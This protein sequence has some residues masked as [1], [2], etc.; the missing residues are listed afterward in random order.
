[1]EKINPGTRPQVVWGRGARIES[2]PAVPRAPP[3][4]VPPIRAR[5]RERGHH[6]HRAQRPGRVTPR[7]QSAARPRL[8]PPAAAAAG[9]SP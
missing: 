7:R 4:A 3:E 8:R 5:D 6:V 2:V 9:S 1:M